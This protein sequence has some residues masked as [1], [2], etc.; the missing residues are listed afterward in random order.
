MVSTSVLAGSLTVFLLQTFVVF[1]GNSRFFG[2][3]GTGKGWYTNRELTAKY[4]TPITPSGWAFSIWALIYVWEFFGM[5][6]LFFDDS[7][8][9]ES[10]YGWW[11]AANVAQA[12]WSLFFATE[13]L[14]LAAV[15]LTT[16]GCSLIPLGIGLADSGMAQYGLLTCPIWIHGG[17][18]VAATLVNWNL[19]I[20]K[21]RPEIGC[22]GRYVNVPSALIAMS[23]VTIFG[24]CAAGCVVPR[25]AGPSA[26]P[27]SC[28]LIWALVAITTSVAQKR[29][30]GTMLAFD[31]GMSET[32]FSGVEP[33]SED[34]D[35][36]DVAVMPKDL[37]KMWMSHLIYGSLKIAG[38][39]AIVVLSLY[40]ATTLC[41]WIAEGQGVHTGISSQFG[42]KAHT[43]VLTPPPPPPTPTP[44]PKKSSPAPA[45][46]PKKSSP[47]P[48]PAP[49]P[50]PPLPDKVV[51]ELSDND[52]PKYWPP[53]GKTDDLHIIGQDQQDAR[54]DQ[55]SDQKS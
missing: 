48:A 18:A 42:V 32:D 15:C 21:F 17:W 51:P 40:T 35:G 10:F 2:C 30:E 14:F 5:I 46:T 11:I 45:P 52:W 31:L 39:A 23:F 29:Q 47:A 33:S 22:C 28:A 54:I 44:T 26:I 25:W 16:I 50:A 9:W 34:P 20:H 49:A 1:G 3:I 8:Q 7:G 24:A 6:Y 43:Q 55:Q 19:V 41:I 37:N 13:N 36:W 12:L 38:V 4:G 27:F 53:L